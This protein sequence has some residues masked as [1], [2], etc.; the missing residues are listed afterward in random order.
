M[1]CGTCEM[2][3]KFFFANDCIIFKLENVRREREE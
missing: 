1:R 2:K 3:I